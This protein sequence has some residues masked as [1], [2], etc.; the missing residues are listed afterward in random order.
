[1]TR[2]QVWPVKLLEQNNQ[3]NLMIEHQWGKT[4]AFICPCIYI[5]TMTIRTTYA[6]HQCGWNLHDRILRWP[7]SKMSWKN[8]FT[9]ISS[10]TF[11]FMLDILDVRVHLRPR[12]LEHVCRRVYIDTNVDITKHTYTYVNT[13]RCNCTHVDACRCM[14]NCMCIACGTY[15]YV[16]V[17]V[18]IFM[19]MS[20]H[21]YVSGQDI[22][23]LDTICISRCVCTCMHVNT[24]YRYAHISPKI[25][26]LDRYYQQT[27]WTQNRKHSTICAYVA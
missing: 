21:P 3:S 5:R 19:D 24:Y 6:E 11:T 7:K 18:C 12:I 25:H 22:F 20:L 4:D 16:S 2:L 17:C 15:M 1:M 27:W 8:D 26:Q 14:Y 10:F 23:S 9:A 13:Y